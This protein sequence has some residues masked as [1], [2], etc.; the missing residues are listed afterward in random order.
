M[1]IYIGG[2]PADAPA[3]SIEGVVRLGGD[4]DFISGDA[5]VTIVGDDVADTIDVRVTGGP[6]VTDHGTL[7]GLEDAADHQYASLVDGTRPF[8]GVV[9]G[10]LPVADAD[11]ATKLYVD[12]RDIQHVHLHGNLSGIGIDDHHP[13][14]HNTEHVA[15]GTDPIDADSLGI[16]FSPSNYTQSSSVLSGHLEGIDTALATMGAAHGATHVAGGADP[17]DGDSLDIDFVPTNY[18]QTSSVLSGHLEGID[19]DLATRSLI[20]HTH[21]HNNLSGIGVDDHHPQLH[22]TEHVVGGNDPI[23]ADSLAIDFSPSQY[24]ATSVVLSGHLEGIDDDLATRSLITHTHQHNNLSGISADD[25]HAQLHNAEHVAGG[26]DPIDADSLDIG[27]NPSNYSAFSTVLSGHLQGIDAQLVSGVPI[28][29]H[30]ATHVA[31]GSDPLD[32]DSLNVDFSPANYTAT[33][34][35][36]SGHLEGVDNE[37]AIKSGIN[38]THQHNNLSGIGTDDHHPQLHNAEHVAGGTDPIDADSLNVDFSPANYTVT[39]VV[40]SGHLEGVDNELAVKAGINHTHQHNNLSGISADDHHPQLHNAEHVTGGAD[41]ID[42]DSLDVDYNPSNYSA[43]SAIL[44]GHLQGIDAQL[45]SGVPVNAHG[46]THVAGGSDPLDADSLDIDYNPSNYSAFSAVLSGHLQGIDAQLVSGVPVSAHGA[47]HV[48][49]GTDP[50]DGDSLAVDFS[51]ANYTA[52]SSVVSGHL[53]GIDNELAI[54][55]GI[56]HTHQHNNLSGIGVDDHHSQLHNA[57]HVAGGTDPID[58]DSLGIDFSP[59]QYTATSSVVSGHLEGIDNDLATRSLITHTHQHNNLSGIGVDDHHPQLHNQDHLISGIDPIDADSLGIDFNPTNY[60]NAS[61]VLSGHLAGIDEML[62]LSKSITVENPT[63]SEDISMFFTNKDITATEMRDV[64]RGSA[65]PGVTW[66]VR[67][68]LGR[69][70]I[71]TEIVTGGTLATDIISGSDVTS[72]NNP[73]IPADS[74]VWLETTTLSGT[75]DELH[76]SLFYKKT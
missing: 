29:A 3:A 35:V 16:D 76:V 37:L 23:D 27:Y 2:A 8:T 62:E 13:Q 64:I 67:H 46:A 56:N 41:P 48:T 10:I 44:S 33:S 9:A 18:T 75:V 11:L 59:S 32:A 30:G 58:A 28:S 51:P 43:F 53:E 39:S 7:S 42:A 74:F 20:T 63:G 26:T 40:L 70:A 60:A 34:A 1:S 22:N 66:T 68:G 72:L 54:K 61:D 55:A 6:M 15:G 69:N 24:T 36:L 73:V 57:E 38:H 19:D 52:T 45:A 49:G 50:I 71:G 14:L 4:I 17:V 5:S 12:D 25:H 65:T 47:D 21:Q 31:G